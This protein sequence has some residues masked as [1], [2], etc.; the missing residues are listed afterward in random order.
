MG[1]N[2]NACTLPVL[3]WASR[4]DSP[5]S[6]VY[7]SD[8]PA[9]SGFGGDI[10]NWVGVLPCWLCYIVQG[11]NCW[12]HQAAPVTENCREKWRL[13]NNVENYEDVLEAV[14]KHVW[15]WGQGGDSV[16]LQRT[17]MMQNIDWESESN[18]LSASVIMYHF[19]FHLVLL[20]GFHDT[21][22]LE[23]LHCVYFWGLGCV[24]CQKDIISQFLSLQWPLL[25]KS[26]PSLSLLLVMLR[27]RKKTKI[28]MSN[29]VP[30]FH[31]GTCHGMGWRKR[32]KNNWIKNVTIAQM[33]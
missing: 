25:L 27:M 11:H 8:T 19:V 5:I 31:T 17:S 21:I 9:V 29:N 23:A 22:M 14:R 18:R 30:P 20:R 13:K 10:L 12:G 24:W 15:F 2:R 4:G 7:C 26:P 33:P 32:K 3:V 1:M 28:T 6:R 16:L